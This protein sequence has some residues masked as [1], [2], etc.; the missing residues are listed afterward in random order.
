MKVEERKECPYQDT[1][2]CIKPEHKD[3][4][5]FV[6]SAMRV[7]AR[8]EDMKWSTLKAVVIVAALWLFG[9]FGIGIIEKIKA[10]LH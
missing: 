1:C 10:V 2:F 9:S 5:A 3:D 7:M 6:R 8:L 4:H